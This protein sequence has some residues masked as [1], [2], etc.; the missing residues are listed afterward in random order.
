M[1]EALSLIGASIAWFTP[2][3]AI[4]V[5][6]NAYALSYTGVN[7]ACLTM[8]LMFVPLLAFF[9]MLIPHPRTIGI[10]ASLASLVGLSAFLASQFFLKSLDPEAQTL[11]WVASGLI[12]FNFADNLV[13]ALVTAAGKTSLR[14][15]EGATMAANRAPSL[16]LLGLP[17]G[18]LFALILT[19]MF[20]DVK[21]TYFTNEVEAMTICCDKS[22]ILII[23]A[24]VTDFGWLLCGGTPWTSIEDESPIASKSTLKDWCLQA[25]RPRTFVI[26]FELTLTLVGVFFALL[27][28]ENLTN[29]FRFTSQDSKILLTYLIMGYAFGCIICPSMLESLGS[30][31]RV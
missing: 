4:R 18:M 7:L 23:L 29:T 14:A 5:Y 13:K 27:Q 17:I 15:V 16:S 19:E 25:L 20:Y 26:S 21:D 9:Y 12:G 31:V 2:L 22:M 11:F 8:T 30:S 24:I 1:T 10:V 28:P 3:A 6:E